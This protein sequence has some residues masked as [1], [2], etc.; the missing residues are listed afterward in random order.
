LFKEVKHFELKTLVEFKSQ[1]HVQ[2]STLTKPLKTSKMNSSLETRTTFL[3]IE[4]EGELIAVFKFEDV[5]VPLEFIDKIHDSGFKAT[6]IAQEDYDSFDLGDEVDV[7]DYL[8][9][10]R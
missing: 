8:A 1:L 10:N 5:E 2:T 4:H 7:R 3:G 9:E 6:P